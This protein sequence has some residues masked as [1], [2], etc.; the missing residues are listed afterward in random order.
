MDYDGRL[1][2]KLAA[3]LGMYICIPET[4]ESQ[5]LKSLKPEIMVIKYLLGNFEVPI[6]N[7]FDNFNLHVS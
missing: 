4:T 2:H 5:R 7:H 6:N 1:L 3:I